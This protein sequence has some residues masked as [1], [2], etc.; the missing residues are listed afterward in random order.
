MRAKLVK[1]ECR[2]NPKVLKRRARRALLGF[3]LFFGKAYRFELFH[4]AVCIESNGSH[5]LF[6]IEI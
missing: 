3:G 4:K 6:L 2:C 5:V 1:V